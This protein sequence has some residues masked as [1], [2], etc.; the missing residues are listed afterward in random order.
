MIRWLI[1]WKMRRRTAVLK[2]VGRLGRS[3]SRDIRAELRDQGRRYSIASL[4]IYLCELEAVGLI[5]SEAS[6]ERLPERG[7]CRT[8]CYWAAKD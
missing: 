3:T 2:A 5:H 1:D 6:D 7:F 8:W 4:L